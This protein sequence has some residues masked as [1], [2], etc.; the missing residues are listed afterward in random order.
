MMNAEQQNFSVARGA[1]SDEMADL[2]RARRG[3]APTSIEA[4]HSLDHATYIQPKEQQVV[5]AIVANG[6]L[7]RQQ[8]AERS[9]MPINC[10]CGRV[11]SLLEARILEEHGERLDPLT[12]KHQKLVRVAKGA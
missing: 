7:S 10:V 2:P 8:I 12:R 11:S 6:P 5:D 9:G 4:Y 1:V 3:V